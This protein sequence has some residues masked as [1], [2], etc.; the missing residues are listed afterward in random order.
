MDFSKQYV[1]F[2]IVIPIL[3]VIGFL[4][5]S[6]IDVYA[7]TSLFKVYPPTISYILTVFLFLSG[8]GYFLNRKKVM[9][10]NMTRFHIKTTLIGAIICLFAVIILYF[11]NKDQSRIKE[12]S[13]FPSFSLD[14]FLALSFTAGI[15][16]L[17]LGFIIYVVN[18]AITAF[19]VDEE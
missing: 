7:Y 2:W 8:A 10:E 15:F 1:R 16:I 19:F 3:L 11:K 5:R 6:T 12:M 13:D 14:Q 9:L 17:F 4:F 18:T